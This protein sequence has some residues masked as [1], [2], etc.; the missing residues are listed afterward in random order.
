MRYP[1]TVKTALSQV[2]QGPPPAHPASLQAQRDAAEAAAAAGVVPGEEQDEETGKD[3]K[4]AA[5]RMAP[6]GLAPTQK[7]APGAKPVLPAPPAPGAMAAPVDEA[8]KTP[9]AGFRYPLTKSA[10]IEVTRRPALP[11]APRPDLHADPTMGAGET[12][13]TQLANN[14]QEQMV[15]AISPMDPTYARPAHPLKH[16]V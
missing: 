8:P 14:L 15:P 13:A 2:L 1:M 10:A 12:L 5:R 3:K 6:A 11:S 16:L 7:K 9:T 4:T